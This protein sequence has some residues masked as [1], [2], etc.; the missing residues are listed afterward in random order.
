MRLAAEWLH[1]LDRRPAKP[2]HMPICVRLDGGLDVP[3]LEAAV[4]A[5]IQR[6]VELRAAF[7]PLDAIGPDAA[8]RV[9]A[10]LRTPG[11]WRSS[12][13]NQSYPAEARIEL[14]RCAAAGCAIDPSDPQFAERY[15]EEATRPFAYD[16]A[17]LVRAT[18]V[19]STDA[20][21]ALILV[22]HHLV[23]DM[24]SMAV[25]LDDLATYYWRYAGAVREPAVEAS[26]DY[27]D[28]VQWQRETAVAPAYARRLAHLQDDY[29]QWV[30]HEPRSE[31]FGRLST[32]AHDGADTVGC[33]RLR[34]GDAVAERLREFCKSARLTLY[35][36]FLSAT[37]LVCARLAGTSKV[38]LWSMWA[39]RTMPGSEHAVG[40]FAERRLVGVAIDDG[41]PLAAVGEHVRDLSFGAGADQFLPAGAIEHAAWTRASMASADAIH[42]ALDAAYPLFTQRMSWTEALSASPVRFPHASRERSVKVFLASA[43]RIDLECMYST[44]VMSAVG[45]RE[46]LRQLVEMAMSIAT[47]PTRRAGEAISQHGETAAFTSERW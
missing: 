5:V 32:P 39:N 40:W 10:N 20:L 27:R 25:M 7:A 8:R 41:A 30:R 34:C 46:Y 23:A 35:T 19:K 29:L 42:V 4:N 21:H 3:A 24:F 44:R 1:R 43:G 18:L 22:V 14:R 17:P 6:H 36:L 2:F 47:T 16:C 33:E 9:F 12:S 28:Y 31:H 37:A 45:A 15:T 38:A 13:F 11:G 26:F